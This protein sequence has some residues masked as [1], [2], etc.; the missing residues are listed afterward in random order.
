MKIIETEVMVLSPCAQGCK[1]K[2]KG[3][4]EGEKMHLVVV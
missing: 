1:V 3:P 2:W 4:T